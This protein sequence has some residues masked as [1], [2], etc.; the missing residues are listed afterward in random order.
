MTPPSSPSPVQDRPTKPPLWRRAV[1][2]VAWVLAGL[3]VLAL[4]WAGAQLA[5]KRPAP[6]PL[7]TDADLPA[8]PRPDE[9]GWVVLTNEMRSSRNP[10]RPDKDVTE[11]CDAKTTLHDRWARAEARAQKLS[12]V[13]HDAATKRWLAL[14]DKASAYPRFADGCVFE[15]EQNCSRPLQ[16]LAIHQMQ[17]AV[18]LHDAMG[19]RWDE[20]FARIGRMMRVDVDFL[21][22]ARS[23]VSQAVAK[24]HVHRSI[25]LVDT[26]LEGASLEKPQGRGPDAALLAA[27]AREVE[28]ML[29]KIREEDLAPIRA[30]IAE[31]LFFTYSLEHLTDSPE[32]QFT[33][34]NTILYDPGHTME[35]LNA[36]FEKWAAYARADGVGDPP[37]FARNPMRFLRNPVG[38]S[39]VDMTGGALETHV[40]SIAKDRTKLLQDRDALRK[41]LS[42]LTN[43]QP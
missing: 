4:I 35:M 5:L 13:A 19:S 12:D 38:Q 18:V 10:E 11:I 6:A 43:P 26:L 41:R 37:E 20:A 22:S 32:W 7:F 8:L 25:R 1:R 34:D 16:M 21:P 9:N 17:E 23:T 15:I 36:R 42:A 14:I 39:L 29:A 2:A 28:P 40:L 30:V 27:L 24:A 3:V 31:Y 33:K